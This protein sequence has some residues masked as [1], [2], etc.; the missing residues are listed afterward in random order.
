MTAYD[1]VLDA[2]EDPAIGVV[3]F[4]LKQWG[5]ND[6]P[7]ITFQEVTT[8]PCR[9]EDFNWGDGESSSETSKFFPINDVSK[10][11]LSFYYRKMKCLDE[12]QGTEIFGSYNTDKASNLMIVFEKCNRKKQTYCKSDEEIDKWLEFKYLVAL[13]NQKIFV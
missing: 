3:K 8:R 1:G 5:L 4:Y 12:T 7:G 11:D 10:R 9:K 2:I 6:E 13:E